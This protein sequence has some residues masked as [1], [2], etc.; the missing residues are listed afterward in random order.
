MKTTILLACALALAGLNGCNKQQQA[1]AG[2]Q[3]KQAGTQ[4]KTAATNAEKG[5]ADGTV[6]M[7][8]KAAMTTSDKLDTSGINVDTKDKV[9]HLRGQATSA[10]QKA[11]AERIARDT[12][13]PDVKVMSELA[14]RPKAAPK[15]VK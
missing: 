3:A 10:D 2:N 15:A 7:K 13:G 14:V 9:V 1:E 11:L 4:I 5:L 6:T 12:V 8:V